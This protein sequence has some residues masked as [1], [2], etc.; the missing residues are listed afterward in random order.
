MVV[1]ITDKVTQKKLVGCSNYEVWWEMSA[2]DMIE[3]N[4]SSGAIDT[5]DQLNVFEAFQK[6]M[7]VNG[8]NLKVA[9][10]GN[11][12]LVHTALTT[13]H[14]KGDILTQDTTNTMVVDFTNTAKTA[15]YGRV[16]GGTFDV[17][18]SVTGSGSGT[19]FTPT[20]IN[21]ML[22]HTALSVTHAADDTLTQANTSATMVV[23]YVDVAKK[24]TWGRITAGTFNTT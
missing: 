10:F 22:T 15:T 5:S 14:A 6:V 20:G 12:K 4:T 1:S 24:H 21:G 13:P 18:N 8:S 11:I 3:L 19:A 23:E 9:D 16:I 17:S 2:G 7:V